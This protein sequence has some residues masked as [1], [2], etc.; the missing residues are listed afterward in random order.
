[1]LQVWNED[2]KAVGIVKGMRC[3]APY[4]LYGAKTEPDYS[5]VSRTTSSETLHW[6]AISETFLFYS[7]NYIEI[8]FPAFCCIFRRRASW[9]ICEKL[10]SIAIAASF[11]HSGMLSVFF[12]ARELVRLLYA[13]M[14][15]SITTRKES[16]S[17]IIDVGSVFLHILAN[18]LHHIRFFLH[19]ITKT[20]L[21]F[22]QCRQF[23]AIRLSLYI[24]K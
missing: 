15:N 9:S 18:Y 23:L 22:F 17:G 21:N 6:R 24:A 3:M 5:K 11:I 19:H 10:K 2:T 7:Q 8:Q 16:A 4:P 12:T 13:S 14:S 1:M 20:F